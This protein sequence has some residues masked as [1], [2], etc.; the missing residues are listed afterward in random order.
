[1]PSKNNQDHEGIKAI[2]N[3]IEN[4]FVVSSFIYTMN[5]KQSLKAIQHILERLDTRISS[6]VN[7]DLQEPTVDDYTE[8]IVEIQDVLDGQPYYFDEY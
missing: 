8:Y 5:D 2:T 4:S 3:L 7:E 6:I 1:M